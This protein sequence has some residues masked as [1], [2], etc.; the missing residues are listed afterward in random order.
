MFWTKKY[1]LKSF[2]EI[3]YDISRKIL[4]KFF[5]HRLEIVYN[6]G[7]NILILKQVFQPIKSE[8]DH[9]QISEILK[10]IQRALDTLY[11]GQFTL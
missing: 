9:W 4:S 6:F 11:G 1:R 2:V 3:L 7:E 5:V 10:S 8:K